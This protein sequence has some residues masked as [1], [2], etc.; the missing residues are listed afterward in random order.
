MPHVSA[1]ICQTY[2]FL[3]ETRLAKEITD[4]ELHLPQVSRL[5]AERENKPNTIVHGEFLIAVHED[6]K[7]TPVTLPAELQ[8]S[9]AAAALIKMNK[10]QFILLEYTTHLRKVRIVSL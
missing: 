2:A 7:F 1:N 3:T 6:L 8:T 4:G 9:S 5:R 10:K